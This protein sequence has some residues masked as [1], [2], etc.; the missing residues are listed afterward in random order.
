M[1]NISLPTPGVTP[2]PLWA[3]Q[4][5]AALSQIATESQSRQQGTPGFVSG[6]YYGSGPITGT[7]TAA[8]AV[9]TAYATPFWIPQDLVLDRISIEVTTLI[10]SGVARLG[11]YG[12]SSNNLG[13]P[14]ARIVDAGTV[15][16]TTTGI[17]EITIN[18]S[19]SVGLY[20]LV[21]VNQTAAATLRMLTGDLAP[22]NWTTHA[23]S[24]LLAAYMQT[25]VTGALPATFV[26]NGFSTSA[27][28][29][30]VRAF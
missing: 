19:L 5:N 21:A 11:I 27:P 2:G 17:K 18:Q 3:Q 1:P 7:T 8:A 4:V 6:R 28:R 15:A 16:T 29:V 26:A 10:A 30:M 12:A 14:S 23:G 9:G 24:N 25:G 22:V 20:Y 13:Q